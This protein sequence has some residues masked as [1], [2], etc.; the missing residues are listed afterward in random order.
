MKTLLQKRNSEQK[1]RKEYVVNLKMSPKII[2]PIINEVIERNLS[3]N[4]VMRT[5]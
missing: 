4:D 1:L 2:E 5:G 3:L